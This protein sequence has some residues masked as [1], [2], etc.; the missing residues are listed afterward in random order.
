LPSVRKRWRQRLLGCSCL[1]VTMLRKTSKALVCFRLPTSASSL[2]WET[3][4]QDI[5]QY[6]DSY[7]HSTYNHGLL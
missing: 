7:F 5:E 6:I 1:Q 4:A 2:E 3:S